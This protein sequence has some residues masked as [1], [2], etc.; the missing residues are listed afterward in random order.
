MKY[1]DDTIN[2]REIHS[3]KSIISQFMGDRWGID[4]HLAVTIA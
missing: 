2:I 3:N 1:D 4:V